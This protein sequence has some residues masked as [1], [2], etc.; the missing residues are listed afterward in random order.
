[1]IYAIQCGDDGPVKFGLAKN[2]ASRLAE[3]QTG[4]PA[5]LKLLVAVQLRDDCERT[6]HRWLREERVRGEWF[7]LGPKT[8]S[9]LGD[10]Q[11]RAALGPGDQTDPDPD[12]YER[13]YRR[14]FPGDFKA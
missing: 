14:R 11:I 12:A 9:V 8:T 7:T 1:M 5:P 13:E 10:L 6:I 4:N 3:L 2:P